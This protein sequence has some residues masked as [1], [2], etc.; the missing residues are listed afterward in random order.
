LAWR[1]N[2]KAIN[3]PKLMKKFGL[4]NGSK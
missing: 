4:R 2:W 3:K 1:I